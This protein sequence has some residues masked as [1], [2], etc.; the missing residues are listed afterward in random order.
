MVLLHTKCL[1]KAFNKA[2]FLLSF[3]AAVSLLISGLILSLPNQPGH[4][5]SLA[6]SLLVKG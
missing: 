2:V 1:V 3:I 5:I 6:L 4:I